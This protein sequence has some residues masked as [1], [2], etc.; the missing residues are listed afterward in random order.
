MN[1]NI[2]KTTRLT[3]M[4]VMLALTVIFVFATVLPSFAVSIAL[5]LFLPTLLT[6]I[7]YG[8]TSGA[9]MGACAGAATL[10]RALF[11]PLSPFD[12]FFINPLVSV[13]PRIFIG[14]VAY[15][16]FALLRD[17]LKANHIISVAIGAS[18]GTLTNT[19]LVVGMLY[20]VNGEIMVEA[21]GMGFIVG[22]GT[23][24][25]ANGIIEIVATAIVVPIVYET[26]TRYLKT[27]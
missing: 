19:V 12:Y 15:Y 6:G 7:I 4:G 16:V 8:P 22:L 10:L 21:M 18:M 11:F 1:K 24:F 9:I 26:Y 3:F 23:L 13:L 17:K 25:L 2:N 27:K 5:V 14:V 20:L